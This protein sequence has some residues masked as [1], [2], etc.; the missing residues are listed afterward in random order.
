M[1]STGEVETAYNI[2]QC[3]I[4][5]CLY[6]TLVCLCVGRYRFW[7]MDM[8]ILISTFGTRGDVQPYLALAVGLQNAGHH[9]TLATSYNYT[10]WIQAYGMKTHPVPFSMAEY[11]QTPKAQ[12]ILKSKNL[13]RQIGLLWD[14]MR[15]SAA[16]Q[17]TVWAAIQDADFVIQSPSSSGALEAVSQR[18]IPAAFAA[19][20]PFAPTRAFPSFFMGARRFTFGE[21]YNFFTHKLMHDVLWRAMGGPVTNPLRKRLG[22][23]PWKSFGQVLD[24]SRSVDI[25]WL[26]GFSPHVI[27]KP[28]DW[29]ENQ[30]VTGYWF[31]E[32]PPG[33]QPPAVLTQFLNS[34]PPPVYVGFGSMNHEDPESQ[35]HL[36]LRALELSGQ[37]GVLVTGWGGLTRQAPPPHV[38]F[39]VD[40]P[41]AWLF[42]R[43]AAVVHHGG[44]GTTGAG[45]RAGIPSIV[46]PFA[47]NDQWAW[48]ERVAKLGVGPS[49]P[50]IQKLTAKQLAQ[51]IQTAV[52]D[53]A[54][55][56]RA[57]TLG[58]KIRAEDGLSR[59]VEIIE[60]AERPH[61][62]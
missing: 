45:L 13:I 19:P 42:P 10:P 35:T 31:L 55:R 23:R 24:H 56:A 46:T 21:G 1:D 62:W 59:A 43:M 61:R 33:W 11:L 41:H 38:F 16:A 25:P 34:G 47:P 26:Y 27:P 12:A 54:L 39:A 49:V 58:E 37:R 52:S 3:T 17:E 44:A 53:A 6:Y 7:F 29:D 48:A 40:I 2:S 9:V 22:L 4:T 5:P 14:I 51:A 32:P 30:Y 50:C 36:A 60:H 57:A 15:Q 20:L 28:A 18:N 8:K